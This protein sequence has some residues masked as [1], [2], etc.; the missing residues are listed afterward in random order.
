MYLWI[1][2]NCLLTN[3]SFMDDKFI[4]ICIRIRSRHQGRTLRIL[5]QVFKSHTS[6]YFLD[7][8]MH[9]KF[10]SALFNDARVRR[11]KSR[12]N[13]KVTSHIAYTFSFFTTEK[14]NE[15]YPKCSYIPSGSFVLRPWAPSCIIYMKLRGEFKKLSAIMRRCSGWVRL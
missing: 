11:R 4:V 12:E 7:S 9:F 8:F 2:K 10:F 3:V 15:S 13:M 6:Y 1:R 5:S 14:L